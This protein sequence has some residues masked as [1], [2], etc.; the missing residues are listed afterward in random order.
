MES[1]PLV[2]VITP[3]YNRAGFIDQTIRSALDQTWPNIQLIVVDDGSTDGT[4]ERV[5]AYGSQLTLLT[6]DGHANRGQ[7]ASINLGLR[8]ATGKYLAIL[9]SDDYWEPGKLALQVAF[10]EQHPD[11]GLVYTNGYGVDADGNII[12]VCHREDHV[13]PNDPDRVL[14][15][16]YLALPVNSLVRK[17]VYDQAGP[18]EESFRAG[19]DHDMLVRI[20]ELTRFAYLPDYTWYYRRH[21]GSI[22]SLHQERRWQT[23]FRILDNAS[24]RYP[25]RPATLRRRKAVLNYRMGRIRLAQRQPL[26]AAAYLF[27]AFLQDPFRALRVIV[28]LDQSR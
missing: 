5:A 8:H 13:E 27:K 21:A 23:G 12:Y 16:C 3:A 14:L 24:R 19:Q 1:Q 15:D 18:F 10:L 28:H 25:Y 6:H 26:S 22:S 9:D 20:A 17:S 11:I 2:S 4:L 7:S